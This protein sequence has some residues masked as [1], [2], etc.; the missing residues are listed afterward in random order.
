MKLFSFIAQLAVASG[1][2]TTVLAQIPTLS[3]KGPVNTVPSYDGGAAIPVLSGSS[4]VRYDPP[5]P[6]PVVHLFN[7]D[8]GNR[9]LTLQISGAA[10]ISIRGTVTTS[11]GAIVACGEADSPKLRG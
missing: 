3:P 5:G 2:G 1:F 9:N 6:S 4:I 10:R 7:I 8:G 11:T